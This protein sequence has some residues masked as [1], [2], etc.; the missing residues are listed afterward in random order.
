MQ[1]VFDKLDALRQS[2]DRNR[3]REARRHLTEL[4]SS[5]ERFV[6]VL[7]LMQA[8]TI[9]PPLSFLPPE[10]RM[11]IEV[12]PPEDLAYAGKF[13][14]QIYNIVVRR[15]SIPLDEHAKECDVKAEERLDFNRAL[16]YLL[17]RGLIT[18]YVDEENRPIIRVKG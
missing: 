9:T 1:R 13:A 17:S 2:L 8:G 18:I 16:E 15:G 12:K 5:L 10:T 4:E 6:G 14:P 11:A 7:S 3:P